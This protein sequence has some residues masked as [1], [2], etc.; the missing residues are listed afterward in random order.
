VK[1]QIQSLEN[2]FE[3]LATA[4]LNDRVAQIKADLRNNRVTTLATRL[5]GF[6]RECPAS[7]GDCLNVAKELEQLQLVPAVTI[8]RVKALILRS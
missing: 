7:T 4:R 8:G 2:L 3:T 5:P 1:Q 6:V